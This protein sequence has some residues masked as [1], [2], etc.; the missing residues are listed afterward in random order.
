M[1][2]D[3]TKPPADLLGSSFQCPCGRV[4]T[5]PVRRIVLERDAHLRLPD[6]VD[7]LGLPRT[8]CVVADDKTYD[9]LGKDVVSCL[10]RRKHHVQEIVLPCVNGNPV[11]VD[12]ATAEKLLAS[13]PSVPL[14][15]AV[16]SGSINDLTKLAAQTRNVPYITLPTAPSMNGYTSSIVAL[17]V[18][19]LKTTSTATPPIA[20]VADLD[21]LVD[22]PMDLVTA[23]LGDIISKPVSTADWKLAQ[24]ITGGYFCSR[25]IELVKAF[26]P[27]YLNDPA[28]IKLR[29]PEAIRAL[30]EALLYSGISMIIAGSSSPASGGEHLVSHTLDMQAGLAGRQHAY[31]GSQ[32]GIA[33]IFSAALYER[34]LQEDIPSFDI[35]TV[36]A[37]A[38]SS[39]QSLS[40]RRR[41]WGPLADVIEKEL[42]FKT[43]AP[44]PF[45]ER[46]L[47]IQHNWS[48][49]RS[50]LQ[51]LLRPWTQIRDVLQNA[52]A[53][54]RLTQI[55][56]SCEPF[57]QAV[58]HARQ[59]RRRYTIL[60]LAQDFGLLHK[61]LDD[62]ILETGLGSG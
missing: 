26:E 17:T 29:R 21:V 5:V 31:H 53:P 18:E 41:Y 16:G 58:L 23:G 55:G 6:V 46:L 24:T 3:K 12:Q 42:S 43:L 57:C 61:H 56:L 38:D 7:E 32:V 59:M 9:V 11:P 15:F 28:G 10:V 37:A 13:L 22:S 25:P 50:D 62:I 2:E 54:T 19:G 39:P 47:H 52:G 36:A 33:T 14:L 40:D 44:E 4:H 35:D 30:T 20:V 34:V 60:D 49:I 45:R 48:T 27:G 1:K 51:D 8:A